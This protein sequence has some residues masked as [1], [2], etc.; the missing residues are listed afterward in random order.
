M[1]IIKRTDSI[2]S[3]Q[4]RKA[5]RTLNHCWWKCRVEPSTVEF[6]AGSS[7]GSDKP[8]PRNMLQRS[9]CL[10]SPEATHWNSST[11]IS[12]SEKCKAATTAVKRS[13]LPLIYSTTWRNLTDRICWAKGSK[14]RRAHLY[15][16]V[17]M[18]FKRA[19][20]INDDKDDPTSG[21]SLL[22]SWIPQVC[23]LFKYII[24]Q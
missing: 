13:G 22:S 15:D 2:K 20:L 5:T 7:N 6:S 11:G 14:P 9:T 23:T 4:G 21:R 18:K 8:T 24:P 19:E 12:G 3:W 17:Y 1:A 16:S 10:S